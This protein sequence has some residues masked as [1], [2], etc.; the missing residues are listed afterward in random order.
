VREQRRRELHPEQHRGLSYRPLIHAMIFVSLFAAVAFVG[1]FPVTTGDAAGDPRLNVRQLGFPGLAASAPMAMAAEI[2]A[3]PVPLTVVAP[4]VLEEALLG[5]DNLT[6]ETQEQRQLA[7]DSS[8]KASDDASTEAN[9]RVSM[10]L[11]YVVQDGDTITSIAK[12]HGIGSEYITW[13]NLDLEDPNRLSPG[14]QIIIPW[15]E[16]IVHSVRA[17]EILSDIARR[18]DAEVEDIL[19]F[20]ANDVPDPSLLQADRYIFVPGGRVV[21]AAPSRP[22][23]APP[24]VQSGDWFWPSSKSGVITSYFST[25]HPLGIDI[26]LVMNTP[27]VA[28]RDGVVQAVNIDNRR[29]G[30]G[31]HVIIAHDNGYES[32]YAHLDSAS[33]ST[34]QVVSQGDLIGLSG[35]TGRST[36][37]HLHFEIRLWNVPQNPLELVNA[38]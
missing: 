28:T 32:T 37:P 18:Y 12:A 20:A 2:Q 36:G 22:G 30:Y 10:Y 7:I 3:A 17:N 16:G 31:V 25:W 24:P 9:A 13:N 8:S 23:P 21:P 5:V 26:G 15:E 11:N 38:E 27:I 19:D 35:N 6:S 1:L 33:V 34:G 29:S 14:D 4:G